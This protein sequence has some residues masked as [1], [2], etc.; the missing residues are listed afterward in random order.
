MNFKKFLQESASITKSMRER[1]QPIVD[2]WEPTH[3]LEG[4]EGR[5]KHTLAQLLQ[6]QTNQL[7]KEA[8]RTGT[9]VG[10]EEWSDIALPLVRKI[11]VEQL[12]KELVHTQSMNMPTGVVFYLDFVLDEDK[13]DTKAIYN[14]DDSVYGTTDKEADPSGGFYGGDKYSYSMNYYS[15]SVSTT[16]SGSASWSDLDYD[17]DLS[18]SV[19]SGDIFY[20]EIAKDS[21]WNADFEALETFTVSGSGITDVIREHTSDTDTHVRFYHKGSVVASGTSIVLHYTEQ[22]EEHDRGDYELGQAGVNPI[23]EM[24]I[25]VSQKQIVAKTRKLKTEITPELIQDLNAYQSLDAQK[26]MTNMLS[27]YIENEEDTEILNMLSKASRPVTRYWSAVPGRYV[28]AKTGKISDEQ[29]QYTMGPHDWYKTLGIRIRDVSNEIHKRTLR[30]GANW[31]VVSPK[32]S[33]ILESFNT[34]QVAPENGGGSFSMG[35]EQVGTVD[36]RIKIYK[37]PYYKDNEILMGFKGNN[38][39][40]SG[41]AYCQYV[42]LILTPPITDPDTFAVKQGIMTRNAKIVLRNEFYAR[43]IVRDLNTV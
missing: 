19:A 21:N 23:S 12:A 10:S 37:N 26:E 41:A 29:A 43:I 33:T 9:T 34:Y 22:P 39:L 3:L 4:L 11:F 31:M 32:V 2:R 13:P 28:N 7:I 36:G 8:S 38:F 25:K 27:S 1:T 30:G 24:N 16:D 35:V 15:A 20:L 14:A 17:D 6:N 40:E 42:P 18:A 5:D